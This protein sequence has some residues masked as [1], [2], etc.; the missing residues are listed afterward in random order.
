[1]IKKF[2]LAA[3]SVLALTACQDQAS[4]GGSGGSRQE[5]AFSLF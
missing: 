5:I 1:M 2:A 4:S 3:A